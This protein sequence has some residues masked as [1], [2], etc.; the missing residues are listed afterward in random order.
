MAMGPMETEK[1]DP[2]DGA[3]E[4]GCGNNSNQE[5]V[6]IA[7]AFVGMYGS[8]A[9]FFILLLVAHASFGT[10][11]LYA[12]LAIWI[13]GMAGIMFAVLAGRWEKMKVNRYDTRL[14]HAE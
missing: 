12:F 14:D 10:G 5:W 11:L 7:I 9:G 6:Q 8:M 3:R 1:K 4:N 13:L 2:G